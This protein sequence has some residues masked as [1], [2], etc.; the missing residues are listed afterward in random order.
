MIYVNT[1]FVIKW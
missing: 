1:I